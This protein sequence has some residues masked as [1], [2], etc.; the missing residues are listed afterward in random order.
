MWRYPTRT[1]LTLT[2]KSYFYTGQPVN[3]KN[4]VTVTCNGAAVDGA[5]LQ[6]FY[7]SF[8]DPETPLSYIPVNAGH[9]FV[10]VVFP[11]NPDLE[12]MESRSQKAEFFIAQ[13]TAELSFRAAEQTLLWTG[14]A[15]VI[16]EPVL[17][18]NGL[19]FQTELLY[20]YRAGESDPWSKGLPAEAG[21]YQLRAE[22]AET[23][24]HTAAA[25]ETTLRIVNFQHM[26]GTVKGAIELK[27][28]EGT[29]TCQVVVAL[30]DKTNGQMLDVWMKPYSQGVGTVVLSDLNL[31]A[32]GR[33]QLQVKT[34]ILGEHLSAWN[35]GHSVYEVWQG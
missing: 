17:T 24:N 8:S 20:W 7:Y 18:L 9:Y 19:P 28:P 14:E 35:S 12:Q 21:I 3:L 5:Q 2:Q 23:E 4:E 25:A 10:Q 1:E 22:V 13:G 29:G 34:F 27:I 32:M 6:Y 33:E 30:Y 15:A 16:Q 31:R 26:D 11:G